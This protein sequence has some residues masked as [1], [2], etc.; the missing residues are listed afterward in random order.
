VIS[1]TAIAH[2]AAIAVRDGTAGGRQLIASDRTGADTGT[3]P[4]RVFPDADVLGSALADE[5][6]AGVDAARTN[7]RRYILGCPGGRSARSTYDALAERVRGADIRHVVIAMMDDYVVPTPDGGFEHCPADAHYSCRRF[8]RHEIAGPLND[9]AAVGVPDEHVWL[10]DPRDPPAYRAR[11]EAAGGVDLFIVA[12]G[13]SDGHVAFVKPGTPLESDVS[14]IPLAETTR[15]DN[16]AT[17]PAFGSLEE[18]PR[19]GVSVGL[20]T[21][22]DLSRSVRLVIHSEGKRLA[23]GRVLGADDF[24]PGWPATFIHRCRGA[25]IWLDEAAHPSGS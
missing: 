8:A 6:I 16:M 25:Q 15:H 12:S 11:L 4:V 14:I 19:H 13:A 7:G 18:V 2:E 20:G 9:A 1:F 24:D 10:P 23:A 21:I 5:I 17:F 22:R 3:T